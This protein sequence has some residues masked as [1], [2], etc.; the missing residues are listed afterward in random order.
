[1]ATKRRRYKVFG[2]FRNTTGNLKHIKTSNVFLQNMMQTFV[3]ILVFKSSTT[4]EAQT[5]FIL[6]MF[7]LVKFSNRA[8]IT[9]NINVFVVLFAEKRHRASYLG[10]FQSIHVFTLI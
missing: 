1:M 9:K 5:R 3:S 10:C 6:L 2:Y 8:I 4:V 7:L